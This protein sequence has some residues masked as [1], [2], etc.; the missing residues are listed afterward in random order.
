M[1][2]EILVGPGEQ[3]FSGEGYARSFNLLSSLPK[4]RGLRIDAIVG[5]I[6]D[7][8]NRQDVLLHEV[9]HRRLLN[10][11]ARS[12]F[13]IYRMIKQGNHDLYHHV[14]M[15]YPGFDP[16]LLTGT[17]GDIP[18]ILG[19]AEAGHE[20]PP[21][22]FKMLL[23]VM[24]GVDIS[25]SLAR[26]IHKG[27]QQALAPLQRLR[28]LLFAQTLQRADCIVAVNTDTKQFYAQHV[29]EEKIAVIPYG[30]DLER[31]NF[32]PPSDS[33][34]I[35][36]VG[37]LISRKGFDDLIRAMAD[38]TAQ[39]PS[40]HLHIVG[41]GPMREELESLI[42]N[43]NLNDHIT[44]HGFVSE[45]KL[46]EL[47]NQADVFA[48]P[49]HSEGYPH[50]RLE[51]MAAGCPVVGTDVTGAQDI[52]R[53]GRDGFIVPK[54]SPAELSKCLDQLLTDTELARQ[55]AKNARGRVEEKHDWI[56]V[57]QQYADLYESVA[58]RS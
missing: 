54:Q 25:L 57:A 56:I 23:D 9:I 1:P 55:M 27:T 13:K 22:A 12:Y 36:T 20:L 44:L 6:Q 8:V 50:V 41:D 14:N 43:L 5:N 39:V 33:Q 51:A 10:Y 16:V 7:T 46:Q 4:N 53:D 29:S 37:R 38:V 34:A 28:D 42:D 17:I 35:L 19:P 47:Y 15:N 45:C 24:F 48:H 31:F 49:S 52:T 32:N 2:L 40:T 3:T 26:W 30:V 11:Q 21:D 58:R 18:V